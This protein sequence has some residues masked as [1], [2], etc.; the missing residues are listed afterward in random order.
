MDGEGYE[1]KRERK[2]QITGGA[3]FIMQACPFFF[4]CLYNAILRDNPCPFV[5]RTC[6]TNSQIHTNM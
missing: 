4:V 1:M 3:T 2:R 6:C 5:L